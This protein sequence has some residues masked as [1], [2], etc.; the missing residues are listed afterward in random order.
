MEEVNQLTK[1]TLAWEL[2]ESGVSKSHIAK[3]LKLNRET[4]HIWVKG[5]CEV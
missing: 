2:F 1:I 5:I 3:Q 4:V